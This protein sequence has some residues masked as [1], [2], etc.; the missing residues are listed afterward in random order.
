MAEALKQLSQ[1]V[2]D[3][4]AAQAKTCAAAAVDAGVPANRVVGDGLLA[5]MSVVGTMFK[6]NEMFVPEVLMSARA[7]HAGLDVLK[8]LLAA[9]GHGSFGKFVLGTVKGD[10]HDIGKNLVGMMLEG[11]GFEV[12]DLGIDVPPEKFVDAI[13]EH[14]PEMVGLSALLT[15]T[16]P[17]LEKT[18]KAIEESGLRPSVKVF[19]GG[20]VVNADLARKAGADYYAPDAASAAE[21]AAEVARGK[22]R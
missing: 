4:D 12:V 18:I 10:L 21:L 3:G 8:P 6:A 15:T 2:I 20:A 9:G 19:T 22:G 5:G 14:R 1:A 11:A 17:A 7:M 13:R 16:V